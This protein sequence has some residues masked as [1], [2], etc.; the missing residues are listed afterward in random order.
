MKNLIGLLVVFVSLGANAQ[1]EFK[2]KYNDDK[3][4]EYQGVV[5]NEGVAQADLY[6]KAIAWIENTDRSQT[7][8]FQDDKVG[9][10]I[11]KSNFSTVGK[12]NYYSNKEYHY[13][14]VCDVVLEFKD[15]K[16]RYTLENFKKK[17]SPGEPGSTL[18]YF[19]DNYNP[20]IDSKKNRDK[21]AKMM[22]EIEL[23]IQDQVW[24]LIEDIKKTFGPAKKD[25]W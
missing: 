23:A 19:I 8:E 15:G 14:F 3:K 13:N 7:I 18:E 24:D 9:K 2:L 5:E 25:D 11:A 4:V 1:D 17:S 22:D 6:K 16:T 10:V 12:S 21:Y 20:K